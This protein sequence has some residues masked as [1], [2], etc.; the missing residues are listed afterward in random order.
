[1]DDSQRVRV[2]VAACALTLLTGLNTGWSGP[3]IPKIAQLNGI[4]LGLAGHMVSITA[5][6]S[7]LMLVLGKLLCEKFT[8]RNCLRIAA[9]IVGC[10]MLTLALSPNIGLLAFGAF[11][12]GC[13]SG[14]NSIASTT[15]VL[16]DI[17]RSASN[18]NK[19]NLF[20]G[21]GAVAGPLIAWAG[22]STQWSYHI[23]YLLGAAYAL[24]FALTMRFARV[25]TATLDMTRPV[26]P[27]I[28]K[29]PQLWLFALVIYM[30]VGMEVSSAAWLFT[31]LQ[32]F[33]GLNLALASISMTILWIGLTLGR[34]ASVFLCNRYSA[35]RIT[36]SG[37]T[38]AA[39]AL[40]SLALF[41]GLGPATLAMVLLLGLGF[42]PIFPNTLAA[43]N[44]HFRANTTTASTV[45]ISCGAVGGIT[46]PML[47]NYCF[48]QVAWQFGMF[49]LFGLACTMM[50]VFILLMRNV[51]KG[52][53]AETSDT[54]SGE[55][56]SA[57][58]SDTVAIIEAGDV[59]LAETKVALTQ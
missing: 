25:Q 7:M 15:S 9:A 29:R 53:L 45:V 28:L 52:K 41:S 11:I 39:T 3:L 47:A 57:D 1:M 19:V 27:R 50:T 58:A 21:I 20:F 51:A 24:T 49:V 44:D 43:A 12:I 26:S 23:V 48:N 16:G 31:Y 17:T 33:S 40:V 37:M 22:S 56:V 10:G 5:C 55:T 18:L 30:Y 4:D 54:D 8:S 14:L 46:V 34:L 42:G 36:I 35:A 6:G 13:G 2:L 32:K 59:D 38:L